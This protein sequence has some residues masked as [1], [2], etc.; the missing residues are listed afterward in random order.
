ME[1]SFQIKHLFKEE[2]TQRQN[3]LAFDYVLVKYH[4]AR[5]PQFYLSTKIVF[6]HD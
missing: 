3:T 5:H 1:T 2:K 6:G 4:S